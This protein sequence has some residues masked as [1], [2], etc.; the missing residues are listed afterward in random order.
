MDIDI[1]IAYEE[2]LEEIL[3]LQKRAFITEA[4]LH[5]NYDIEPL[6]QTYESISSDFLCHVFLKAVYDGKIIGSVKFKLSD[7]HV[8]VGKLIVDIEHRKQGL[9]RKLLTEIERLNPEAKKFQLFTA[10]SSTHNIRLYESIGYQICGEY[11]DEKQA[12]LI[13]VEMEKIKD[14]EKDQ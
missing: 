11:K 7:D 2:D 4:K 10:A 13:L 6:K 12:D 9:G 14:W 8:W 5:G 3:R 1:H